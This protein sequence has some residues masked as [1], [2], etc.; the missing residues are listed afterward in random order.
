MNTNFQ[1]LASEWLE[2]FDLCK[3]AEK[4]TI[5]DPRTSLMI[6]RS[7]LEL[8]VNW[9]FRNDEE[10]DLPF[11]TSLNSLMKQRNFQDQFQQKFYTEI[12]LI[13]KVGN[14]A[15]HNKKVSDY[16]SRT[17]IDH[18]FYFSK[19]FAKSY[20]EQDLGD[21]GFFDWDF[22]PTVGAEALS[23]KELDKLQEKFDGNLDQF[24][25]KLKEAAEKNAALAE[26]NA[27]YKRQ[28]EDLQAQIEANKQL[29]NIAEE[30]IHPRNEYETR[31]YFIDVSL[32]EAGWDLS[33]SKDKE[34][35]V[36][37]MPSSTNISE[38][39][40]IDYVLWDDDGL[41]LAV[42]EAKKTMEN[43]SKGENQAQLYAESLEKM[44]GRRPVMYYTN[45]FETYLWDD[46]FYKKSRLVHG[47]YTKKELQTLMFRRANRH[48]I[49]TTTIDTTITD[50]AYQLRAI[51]S[52]AEHLAGN[53]K[54]SGKLIGTHRA[55][56]LVLATGTG[57]TR[58]SIAISKLLL[59]A[60]WAKRIL[61]LAD[62]RSLVRQA[63]NNFVK[64][65][66]EHTCV[67]LLVEKNYKS[68]FNDS[69]HH[70]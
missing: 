11:D 67:N 30:T 69:F 27:L 68:H 14:L 61:F 33:G 63:K 3:K 2:F 60:N 24:K 10:L 8:A 37:Y 41:P 54:Y 28:I 9:M 35:K 66:P 38:T 52:V 32:R 34:F 16:D 57:K 39:G 22:V 46:Q 65:M 6:S 13:R 47:F 40:Y 56:L 21:L 43:A 50:R 12:D 49:R 42:V 17:V 19:W 29:A 1:F 62:R 51:R 26:S 4:F 20:S 64:L 31:K 45:G 15:I 23:K 18:L 36:Q 44:F 48:D 5:T 58:I 7:A 55:A 53:D 25:N 70:Y 59:E